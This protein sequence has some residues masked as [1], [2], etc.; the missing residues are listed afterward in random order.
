MNEVILNGIIKDIE[1]SHTIDGVDF[2]KAKLICKRDD[3]RE[4]NI[5]LRFKS[6]SCQYKDGNEIALVGNIR[7][8]SY[9]GDDDRNKVMIYVFT[10]FNHPE[11]DTEV[12]NKVIVEGRIC[13]TNPLRKT[14]SGKHNLHMILANNLMT[15]DGKRLNSYIPCISWGKVA[16]NLSELSVNTKL[17]LVGQLHSREHVK[18]YDDGT[19]EIRVAHELSIDSYE[20]IE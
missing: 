5:N 7:S 16:R 14:R 4:D 12:H 6:F 13:K 8:Y 11:G 10:Y 9:I 15:G 17:R 19:E 3:G 18:K 1:Y 20:V 2:N